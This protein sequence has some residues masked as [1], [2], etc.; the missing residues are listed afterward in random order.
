MVVLS[1]RLQGSDTPAAEY[2]VSL[3]RQYG[4][5]LW[6]DQWYGGHHLL[7]YSLLFP[8]LAGL[9]G[10]GV[11]G[12]ASCLC[13]TV[14]V[15]RIVQDRFGTGNSIG[16]LW[17]AVAVVG[18]LAVG[19]YPFSLGTA[20]ATYAVLQILRGHPVRAGLAAVAASLASPLIGLFLLIG[21]AA[22]TRT[23][24]PRELAPLLGGLSGLITSLMFPE[25]G[26][27]PFPILTLTAILVVAGVGL[28]I[29]PK[30]AGLVRRCLVIYAGLAVILFLVPS[31]VGG[32]MARPA[33]LLA[34]PVAA[35]VLKNRGRLLAA[36]AVPLLVW[37]I[38]PVTTAFASAGDPSSHQAYYA[39]LINFLDQ[40]PT[41]LGRLEI[42]FTRGHWEARF[43]APH[44]PLARGWERQLDT[45]VNAA[46]YQNDLTSGEYKAWLVS[47]GVRFVA[48]PDVPLDSSA[49]REATLLRT[50]E[51]YL[52]LIWSDAHWKV[53]A[54]TPDPRL[55]LGPATLTSLGVNNFSVTF[56]AAGT[57]EV[58]VR[59]SDYWDVAF[60]SGACVAS[61]PGGW[62]SV[63]TD[64]PGVV[65]I[66]AQF[67]MGRMLRGGHTCPPV[68]PE[69]N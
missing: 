47:R 62:T 43:V 15:T 12:V 45:S 31:P 51:P 1:L 64:K 63:T 14:C 7:G 8:P 57:A 58:L 27:F 19:R 18:D 48:L 20:F 44:M 4:L 68:A 13:S 10:V 25:G 28:A 33:I 56:H 35:I 36:I 24:K 34:G 3:F 65:K 5:V 55:A 42:P 38:A 6:D 69:R 30:S 41:P 22:W 39:G 17:F 21:A 2:R 60:P 67:S 59:W 50:P 23:R 9:V 29:A 16:V 53:W 46:L 52:Q 32:N 40:H 37:Q 61:T 49:A 66:S 11:L 26:V 54:V